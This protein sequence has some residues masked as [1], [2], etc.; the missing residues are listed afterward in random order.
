[1]AEIIAAVVG[2]DDGGQ[3]IVEGIFTAQLVAIGGE[4]PEMLAGIVI[5]EPLAAGCPPKSE[6]IEDVRVRE[7]CA[8]IVVHTHRKRA[9]RLNVSMR[10]ES[11]LRAYASGQIVLGTDRCIY[12]NSAGEFG[13]VELVAV[14]ESPPA[15]EGLK[16]DC[17]LFH[18]VGR[19][20]LS[21]IDRE[22]FLGARA[23]LRQHVG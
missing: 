10:L 14:T 3:D 5:V 4:I 18:V 20:H 8:R 19:M 21:L 15:Y 22:R 9:W 1:M 23:G 16:I 11:A 13:R 12:S 17:C 6:A 7:L 2:G